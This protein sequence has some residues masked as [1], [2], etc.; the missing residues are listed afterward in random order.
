MH[1]RFSI[2]LCG[3]WVVVGLAL[4]LRIQKDGVL[5]GC[6][7]NPKQ[8]QPASKAVLKDHKA[9]HFPL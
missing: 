8:F 7:L 9:N 5:G 2:C 1:M 4:R 6:S 3:G